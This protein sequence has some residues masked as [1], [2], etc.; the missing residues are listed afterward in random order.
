MAVSGLSL[1]SKLP[2]AAEHLADAREDL[3]PFAPPPPELRPQCCPTPPNSAHHPDPTPPPLRGA[4]LPPPRPHH[5]PRRPRPN[6]T[7]RQRDQ[8]PPLHGRR[9]PRQGRHANQPATN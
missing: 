5:L 4:P 7:K 9:N 6:E 8:T 1:E 2:A 3:L